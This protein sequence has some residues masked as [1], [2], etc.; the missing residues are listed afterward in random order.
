METRKAA[1]R[2]NDEARELR[3]SQP[4]PSHSLVYGPRYLA[5]HWTHIVP[6]GPSLFP[7]SGRWEDPVVQDHI[8]CTL[9]RFQG[10]EQSIPAPPQLLKGEAGTSA[11][12]GTWPQIRNILGY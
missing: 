10:T 9:P 1:N 11:W 6:A 12:C 4:T 5:C 2:Q 3:G 7:V 8:T